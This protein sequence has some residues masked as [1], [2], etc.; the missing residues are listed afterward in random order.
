MADTSKLWFEMGVRDEVASALAKNIKTAEKLQK[1][2][3]NVGQDKSFRNNFEEAS[4]ALS[5]IDSVIK[6]IQSQ[7]GTFGMRDAQRGLK[8]I[9]AEFKDLA[10]DADKMSEAGSVSTLRFALGLDQALDKAKRVSNIL[11]S[12]RESLASGGPGIDSG[13]LT[14]LRDNINQV[15]GSR[16]SRNISLEMVSQW[17][18]RLQS[19]TA[20]ETAYIEKTRSAEAANRLFINSFDKVTNAANKTNGVIDDLKVKLG[21]YF[22]LWG[23]QSLYRGIIEVGGAFEQQHIALQSILQDAQKGT[24]IFQQMKDLAVVSPF[25]FSQLASYTKQTAAFGIP[26]EELYD[27]TKRLADLSAGLGVDMQRLILAF[28]QV[29][30]AAVLRGQ[31]LRQFTEAGIPLV[32]ALADEFTKL[33]GKAVTTGDVFSLISKRQVPFEMVKK[34]LW[35]MTNE[36]GR[37]FDMQFVLSDT[38]LGKW[39]NLRDAWEILLSDFAKG[40]SVTG[41]LFKGVITSVTWLLDNI[42]SVSALLQ[43]IAAVHGSR[44]VLKYVGGRLNAGVSSIEANIQKSREQLAIELRRRALVGDITAEQ[45]KSLSALNSSNAKHILLLAQEGR[46]NDYQIKRLFNQR[47]YNKEKLEELVK[48]E[49]I[50]AEDKKQIIALQEKTKN[51]KLYSGAFASVRGFFAKN[52]RMI[53]LDAAISGFFALYQH[54]EEIKQKNKELIESFEKDGKTLGDSLKSLRVTGKTDYSSEIDG[55]K[56]LIKQHTDNYYSILREADSIAD[57]AERYN[58]LRHELELIRDGYTTAEASAKDFAGETRGSFNLLK[59][60]VSLLER[61]PDK[62][63]GLFGGGWSATTAFDISVENIATKIRDM[64]ADID[65][66]PQAKESARRLIKGMMQEAKLT[67]KEETYFKIKMNDFIDLYD[68]GSVAS[69]V[70]EKFGSVIERLAPSIASKIRH[71]KDLTAAETDLL[72]RMANIAIDETRKNYGYL[73]EDLQKMLNNSDFV[74]TIRLRYEND[75]G[76]NELQTYLNSKGAYSL[77]NQRILDNW[78]K[79]GTS[80]AARS[81]AKTDIK[82]AIDKAAADKAVYGKDSKQAKASASRAQNLKD[83]AKNAI[84][85]DYDAEEAKKKSG[86]GTKKD[87]V[88]EAAKTRLDAIKSFYAEYKKY[89]EVYGS[90]KALSIVDALFPT[91]DGKAVVED[92]RGVIESLLSEATGKSGADWEKYRTTLSKLLADIDLD[93]TKEKLSKALKAMERYIQDETS[94]W[95]LYKELKGKAGK[96]FAMLAFSDNVKWDDM[97]RGMAEQLRAAMEKTDTKG[98][99]LEGFFEMDDEQAK[100]FFGANEDQLKLWQEITKTIRKNWV[101]D[102]KEIAAATEKLKTTEEKIRDVENEIADLRRQG[103]GANDPRVIVKRNEL[104]RLRVEAYENSE[105]YLKFYSSIFAMTAEDAKKAGAIIKQNL[106]DQL[107]SGAINA[108]KYLKSI[109]NV[110]QQ[111]QNIRSVRG[112]AFTLMTGGINGLMQKRINTADSGVSAAAIRVQ[113]AEEK[114]QKARLSGD[115][116]RILAARV[117]LDLAKNALKTRQQELFRLLKENETNKD[118]LAT[119]EMVSGV[120]DGMAKAAQQI[121]DMFDALGHE[122]SANTWSDIADGIGAVGSSISAVSGMLKSGMN[123]DIGGVISNAVGIFTNPITAFAKLHDKKLD[124]KIQRSQ[125]EVR[126]LTTEYQNLQKAIENTLGGIYSTGGYDAMFADLQKQRDELQKQYDAETSKKK[127]DSEKVADYEQQLK[128]ATEAVNTFALDMA[129]SLY[130]IDLHSWSRDLTDAIVSAWDNG[131]DAVEAYRN[132]VKDIMKDLTTNILAKKVMERAFDSLGID[133]IIAGM[134]DASSGKL[135]ETAIPRLTAALNAA[136]QSTTNIILGV[137][138]NLERQGLIE[139]GQSG[140]SSRNVIHGDFTEQET[141]LL[142]SYVNAIRGDVSM[143]RITLSQILIAVQGQGEMPIIAQAQLA[144]LEQISANTQR[145]AAAAEAI[146]EILHKATIDKAFGFKIG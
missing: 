57:L 88:L 59:K 16:G 128:E 12:I 68:E 66:N 54:Y 74:A 90:E 112:D 85:Y 43:G 8:K 116:S 136:G 9:R 34:V 4:R 62:G 51:A 99:G 95:D 97:T 120:V 50:T 63:V 71:G 69:L 37:F 18:E 113:K 108:D 75:A 10:R 41:K 48:S 80:V 24:A 101:D 1:Y 29:R 118:I 56:E 25:N 87:P 92:Y 31:E 125:K 91:V 134:M 2:L 131:E 77:A 73:S 32:R 111:L 11:F 139:K 26:Y 52:W 94:K 106:V 49:A 115:Q 22:S 98:Y 46:L 102:L 89:R 65:D 7:H 64:F 67:A 103:A 105:P 58:Y 61:N 40:T 143:N 93:Q 100:K 123:D 70:A 6:Q 44:S 117:D 76:L 110:N 81:A 5:E 35:D 142:L 127:S 45:Y 145:N 13:G 141:G 30:S 122:G 27:T 78:A 21:S 20:K 135:D 130:S 3:S 14:S 60:S 121:S 114:L 15:M 53:A 39:S 36:G 146:Q 55:L 144:Q 84:N 42:Q 137:L 96:D 19:L 82:E 28:G 126:R 138:D 104:K 47:E 140:S 109:K 132:K 83:L 79:E 119:V 124:R 72:S 17:E 133:N 129:K 33:N 86:G 38:L 107:A 23:L